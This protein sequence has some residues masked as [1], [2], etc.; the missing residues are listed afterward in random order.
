VT[1]EA[2]LHVL[3]CCARRARYTAPGGIF[4]AVGYTGGASPSQ[5]A[6]HEEHD[7]MRSHG[8]WPT[9]VAAAI[10]AGSGAGCVAGRGARAAT[11]GSPASEQRR[12]SAAGAEQGATPAQEQPS[13]PTGDRVYD[14]EALRIEV[15]G[16]SADGEPELVA[17]DAQALLDAGNDALARGRADE[18]VA[19]YE[20]LLREFPESRLAA[21]AR[22]NLGL[23]HEARG[24]H[25]RA[26]ELY[27]LLAADDTLGR[28]AVDA[29]VRMAAVLAELGRWSE[30][31]QALVA[32]LARSDLTH[33]DRIEGL[34]RLGYV[35]LEQQD[36]AAAETHLGE[37]LQT[38]EKLTTRLETL[39]FVAMARYYL[40][41]I[42]HRQFRARPM[43][44]P[45]QQL[46]RDLAAKAGLVT[47]AYDRYVEVL[48]VHDAYWGT[49]AGY[50]MSQIYKELWDDVT[51]AP[52]PTQLSPEAA[53]YYVKEV[54][55]RVRPMLEKAMEGH[56]RN[57]ELARTYGT[58]TEW[59]AAS[60]VRADEIAE[61]LAREASGELVTPG[62]AGAI[63][64]AGAAAGAPE[65]LAPASYV[66][67]R[68]DL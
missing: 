56:L 5:K 44:L 10:V 57:L 32:L 4:S 50:Q 18:A 21:A 59:S 6:S 11:V 45:D 53:G 26:L 46:E 63:P 19:R 37:A 1:P 15:A 20:K 36:F 30:A 8:V 31:R 65:A 61:L 49:A 34:A 48:S 29:H 54:H 25:E 64:V 38:F 66:P 16:R 28:D 55:A 23:A 40:A 17:Y 13:P 58:D 43:R 3:L 52:I 24:E 42:P 33:A 47:L 14:L 2:A 12:A 7:E 41:Q 62:R 39:Y 67:A 22:Y 51:S 9:L 27:R 68:P 35:A 60:R